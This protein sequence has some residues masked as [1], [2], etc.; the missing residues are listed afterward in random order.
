MLLCFGIGACSYFTDFFLVNDSEQPIHVKLGLDPRRVNASWCI[1]E[2]GKWFSG[3]RVLGARQG[4]PL[5]RLSFDRRTC[6]ISVDL[7]PKQVLLVWSVSGY[8]H[9]PVT[10]FPTDLEVVGSSGTL[11]YS[12]LRMY[13]L[14]H[15][16]SRK[17]AFLNYK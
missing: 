2:P 16:R 3:P 5:P 6:S 8:P 4:S 15:Q 9:Q 14:F 10:Q 12:G 11:R 1:L 7:E 13:S 17:E